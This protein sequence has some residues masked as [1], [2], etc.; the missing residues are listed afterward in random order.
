MSLETILQAIRTAG[1]AQVSQVEVQARRQIETILAQA[2]QDAV[3]TKMK[4]F[5][6][7]VTPAAKERSRILHQARLEALQTTGNQREALIDACLEAAC[8]RLADLRS[9]PEYGKI[10]LNLIQ[11]ALE[12]IHFSCG[13]K[14]TPCL[15]IDPRDRKL[16][17][18][19]LGKLKLTLPVQEELTCWGGVVARSEDG[20]VVMINTLEARL[21]RASPPLRRGLS[22]IFE[23]E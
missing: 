2:R 20:R 7:I 13:E 8:L 5:H 23:A 22:G 6:S 11:E 9:Q 16:V 10:L 1:E 3:G 21:G 17:E 19:I 14:H 15:L 12:E 4:E 18:D